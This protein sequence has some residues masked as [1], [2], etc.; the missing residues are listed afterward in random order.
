MSS[1]LVEA[2]MAREGV[3]EVAEAAGAKERAGLRTTAPDG[4][5]EAPTLTVTSAVW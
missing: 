2:L 3:A 5:P 4:P 1:G